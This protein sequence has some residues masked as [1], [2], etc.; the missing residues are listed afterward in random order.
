MLDI[1]THRLRRGVARRAERLLGRLGLIDPRPSAPR[2]ASPPSTPLRAP[3]PVEVDAPPVGASSARPHR[4]PA[5]EVAP[6]PV[7]PA[8]PVEPAPVEADGPALDPAQVAE[9][10]D[11]MVRPALQSDGGDIRLVRVDGGDVYVELVGACHACPSSVLT[12]K[13]GVERL[14]EEELPAFR[15]LIQVNAASFD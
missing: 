5:A 8:A 12:M 9:I 6:P 10:L 2:P 4:T 13:M 7:A 11:E 14:L 1:D 15:R 3:E